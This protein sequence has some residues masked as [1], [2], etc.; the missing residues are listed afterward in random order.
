MPA[1]ARLLIVED[2]AKLAANLRRGLDEA[3]FAV[4]V[5]L[6]AEAAREALGQSGYDLMLL[7]LRLPGQ[8]GLEFLADL[9]T[10][11]AAVPVLIL[12]ARDATEERVRGLDGGGDDYLTKPFAFSE[13][14]ARVR[15]LLRRRVTADGPVLEANDI[16]IDTS[17]RVAS[18]GGRDLDLSPK[19]LMV[20]EYLVRHAGLA[21]TR[22]MIGDRGLGQGLQ[23]H[24]EHRRSVHQPPAP[25]ARADQPTPV[26]RDGPRR[27]LYASP[28]IAGAQ[29]QVEGPR[30]SI[31]LHLIIYWTATTA[32]ILFAAGLL[33]LVMFSRAMW[34]ALDA[35]LIEEADT[36][37]AAISHSAA[38]DTNLN[39]QRLSQEKDLGP[40]RRVRLIVGGHIVFDAGDI[41]ADL[42]DAVAATQSRT[43]DGAR[44]RYRFAVVPLRINGKTGLL[45]DGADAA[46]VR[47]TIAHL[48]NVLAAGHP[49]YPRALRRRRLLDGRLGARAG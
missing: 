3:G 20:L 49:G 33:I 27:G 43:V 28:R 23:R 44:H 45:E 5:A 10:A 42:P 16:A 30:L 38:I 18:R 36:T 39:L 22:D 14:L 31:R 37:A 21:V 24:V 32:L 46:P 1:A 7:D 34:G 6:S 2:E 29:Q 4:D 19:E 15:A 13:L 17:R 8:D 41:G 25:E 26:D 48:R 12:T 11:G 40:G 9:R 35:A 47:R